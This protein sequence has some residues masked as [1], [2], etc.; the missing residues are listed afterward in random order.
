MNAFG[1]GKHGQKSIYVPTQ[2]HGLVQR[3]TGST[4]ATVVRA[5]KRMVVDLADRQRWICLEALRENRKW[6]PPGAKVPV[7]LTL[8]HVYSFYSSNRLEV[9]DGLLSSKNLADYLEPWITWVRANRQE[10]VR[11]ADVYEQQVKT[12]VPAGGSFL[13]SQLTKEAVKTWLASRTAAS[14]GTRRKYLYALKSFIAYLVDAGILEGDP[15]AGM[16]AP[17]KDPARE[18]H[19]SIENDNRIV[20]AAIA[21]YKPLFALVKAVGCD[22]GSALERAQKGDINLATRRM[23][24]RGTK[25]DRRKVHQAVIEAWAVPYLEAHLKSIVG[26]HT[27]VFQGITRHGAAS[28]HKSCCVAL[29]IEDYTLKDARHSVAVRMRKRGESFEAIAEQLGTSVYQAVT[30]YSRYKPDEAA[31]AKEGTNG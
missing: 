26:A 17:K 5:M 19:E 4:N 2:L 15:L 27:L 6:T 31:P 8:S 25:T 18:R 28:H 23:N 13:A 16:K 7:K 1:R 29:G 21:K 9:L 14:S 24:V 12:L 10:G 22:L 30:V 11:T 20:G 3:S